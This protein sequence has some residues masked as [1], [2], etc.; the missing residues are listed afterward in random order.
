MSV[1]D[2]TS[3]IANARSCVDGAHRRNRRPRQAWRARRDP[4][5]DRTQV[6]TDLDR[7][8]FQQHL[9]STLAWKRILRGFGARS[10]DEI[11]HV[12]ITTSDFLR[13]RGNAGAARRGVEHVL[14]TRDA[15]G[16]CLH[17]F[18]IGADA[19]LLAAPM[20][21]QLRPIA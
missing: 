16:N 8:N 13:Q 2:G 10:R 14:A 3:V 4:M 15:I 6:P 5:I 11:D 18:R 1:I 7:E 21:R 20:R 17:A 9:G 19:T 12:V